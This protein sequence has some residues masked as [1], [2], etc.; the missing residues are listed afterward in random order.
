MAVPAARFRVACD[1]G[2]LD[3]FPWSYYV[4]RGADPGPGHSL[5]L[6][7]RG[8]AGVMTNLFVSCDQCGT[9]RPM[10]EAIGVAAEQNLPACRG[11]HSHLGQYEPR[12]AAT[13]TLALGATNSWFAMQLRVISVPRAHEPVDHVVADFWPILH[14]LSGL[15]P[16]DRKSVV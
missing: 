9:D 11:R 5:T 7:E 1:N 15:D 13:R 2:H 16:E 3:D 6:S 10:I 14:L 8:S 12:G 4:H